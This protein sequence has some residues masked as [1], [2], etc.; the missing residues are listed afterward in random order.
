[1][2]VPIIRSACPKHLL[3]NRLDIVF[4]AFLVKFIWRAVL[5]RLGQV[6]RLKRIGLLHPFRQTCGTGIPVA[7]TGLESDAS[8]RINFDLG[9]LEWTIRHLLVIVQNC[10]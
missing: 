1:M 10:G 6:R 5:R 8:G 7:D 3:P 2:I 9:A 4:V